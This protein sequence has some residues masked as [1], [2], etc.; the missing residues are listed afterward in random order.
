[1]QQTT[2][3]SKQ[4]LD[5]RDCSLCE[6]RTHTVSSVLIPKARVLFVGEAPGDTEDF[7]G[8]PFVGQAG[9]L[10]D[11][12]LSGIGLDR[13]DISIA[14]VVRCKPPGNRIPTI[15]EVEAC[16]KYLFQEI[17]ELQPELIV[18][19]GNTSLK[20][21]C[22]GYT[23]IT[24]IRGTLLES[25]QFNCKILPTLHPAYILR[26]PNEKTKLISDLRKVQD[27]LNGDFS[28]TTKA[29]VTS[30]II[31]NLKQFDWLIHQLNSQPL[32]V[33]D[34]ETTGFDCYHDSIFIFT[35]SWKEH[36]G[37]LLDLRKFPEDLSYIFEKLS[38][39]FGN[40]S[41][42]VCHNGSFDIEFLMSK[43]I[44]VKNYYSDTILMHYLLDENSNH[45][46]E[47]LAAELTDQGGYD[48]PL[49]NYKKINKIDSY[50]DIPP[51]I[52]YPYAI[53]DADVT[54]RC[55]NKMITRIYAEGLEFV[56]FNI[57]IPIQKILCLTEYIGVSIDILHLKQTQEKY[58]NNI[59]KQLE[60]VYSVPQVLEYVKE[61]KQKIIDKF[62]EK[63]DA[64][65]TLRKKFPNFDNYLSS[66][67]PEKL[68]YEFNIN[69]SK[70]LK[71]LLID[72]M[73]LPVLKTTDKGNVCLNDDVLQQ[74]AKKNKFCSALAQFRSLTHLKSTFLDGTE[75][76]LD[77]HNRVHTD[78]LLFST[79]TGRPSSRD[80]NLNNIPRT[81]TAGDIKDIFCSDKH[82]DGSSDWLVEVDQGQAEFRMWINYSKDPQ[83]YEDLIEGLD[84]HKL[85]AASAKGIKIPKGHISYQEF[86]ELVKDITKA[87]RQQAKNIVFGVMY[88]RGVRSVAEEFVISVRQA[89]T[90]INFF[91]SRYPLAKRWLKVTTEIGRRDGYITNVF[92]RRRRLLNLNHAD[93]WIRAEAERQAVNSPIQSAASDL[94]FL[95]CIRIFKKLW[96]VKLKSRMVL[97]VYDSL[98]F[99]IP[100]NELIDVGRII[101][102]EMIKPPT[103]D[104][105]VPLASDLKIGK[106]W[107][108]LIEIDINEPPEIVF[109]K[110]KERFP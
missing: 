99:N 82:E 84:I 30:Y 78:Y 58:Q 32:W 27:F 1:M 75:K 25:V 6:K 95:A 13:K 108:S 33:F 35:F 7:R 107:G 3:S 12:I 80:P 64:S 59:N 50:M 44:R 31:N 68:N 28:T 53:L 20:L 16:S 83:A 34:T 70:Q 79:V 69:S 110:L 93:A 103:P 77:E 100:T 41:K 40:N 36:S 94:T 23:S 60:V 49:Q 8:I 29:Q 98:V 101:Y 19:L 85:V 38:Q 51:E 24:K 21:L 62:F 57:V 63:W 76:R 71:E 97:T 86:E 104:I 61:I 102:N 90:I 87:E 45:G 52:L 92:G 9:K 89:Q 88:G 5:C 54:L 74:Y 46:L 11:D 39:V 22:P 56:L 42:K 109:N 18:P 72:K 47:I 65:Q 48:L 26:A 73:N 66:I 17:E 4:P 37:A 96:G 55:Y 67:A 10:L 2:I 105:T 15:K 14:N 91:F 81:G 106:N 43:K